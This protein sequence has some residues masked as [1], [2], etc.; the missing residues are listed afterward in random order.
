MDYVD[1]IMLP[2]LRTITN[3]EEFALEEMINAKEGKTKPKLKESQ[4]S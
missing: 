4:S 1:S 3:D 2:L